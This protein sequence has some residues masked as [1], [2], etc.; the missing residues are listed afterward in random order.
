MGAQTDTNSPRDVG[1][2]DILTPRE[3]EMT[4]QMEDGFNRIVDRI[5]EPIKREIDEI[6]TTWKTWVG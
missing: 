1:D 3:K 6:L 5:F 4:K 2:M